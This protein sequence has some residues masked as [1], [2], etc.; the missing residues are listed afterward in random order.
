MKW[1]FTEA[2]L[3]ICTRVELGIALTGARSLYISFSSWK[4]CSDIH[5]PC[6]IKPQVKRLRNCVALDEGF[7]AV[8][9]LV[10]RIWMMSSEFTALQP[11][12]QWPIKLQMVL[13]ISTG[14]CLFLFTMKE[15]CLPVYAASLAEHRLLQKQET[16]S[17]FPYPWEG[18][19]LS[20][21]KVQKIGNNF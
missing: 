8:P 3:L 7:L 10:L 1:T 5:T 12:T 2:L 14:S 16:H 9:Q 15:I 11:G 17:T 13:C 4:R 19:T 6:I 18:S 20:I 21:A